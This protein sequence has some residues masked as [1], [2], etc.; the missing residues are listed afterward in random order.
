MN[1]RTLGFIS[2]LWLGVSISQAQGATP[3]ISPYQA[4]HLAAEDP[5]RG[6]TGI[7]EFTVRGTGRD[8]FVYLNSEEDYRDQ[9]CLTAVLTRGVAATL[10]R[11]LGAAPD[12]AL[13]GKTI[14]V[15]GTA[16]RVRIDFISDGSPTGRY[17]YQ[18][19][20][21]VVDPDKIEVLAG[22]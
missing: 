8:R 20:I 14:R 10:G 13:I 12:M 7:F 11:T 17:Y 21:S 5:S 22:I 2:L 3:T 16:K 19:H 9:R 6:V 15:Q 1:R 4:I 18:T